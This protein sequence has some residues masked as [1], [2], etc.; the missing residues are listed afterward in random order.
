MPAAHKISFKKITVADIGKIVKGGLK[1]ELSRESR[2]KIINC[3]EYLEKRLT[4]S[5]APVYGV[6]TGFGA[7]YNVTISGD[8]LENLQLN[9]VMSHACGT[10]DEISDELVAL[11]L[12]LKAQS[13]SY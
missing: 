10:G 2:N 13:L 5:A 3:R 6:N 8:E 1:L 9:L 7:L 11:M 4:D 12:L